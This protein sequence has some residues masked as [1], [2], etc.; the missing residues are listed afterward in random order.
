MLHRIP[1]PSNLVWSSEPL[2]AFGR[3][4]SADE[5]K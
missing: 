1:K 4:Y 5:V 2:G 3:L